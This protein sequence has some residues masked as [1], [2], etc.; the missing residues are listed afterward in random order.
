M[1]LTLIGVGLIAVGIILTYVYMY[2]SDWGEVIG[3]CSIISGVLIGATCLVFI[4]G[5][6]ATVD[7]K[8]YDAEMKRESI[9]RQIEVVNSEYEDVSRAKI[10]QKAYDWN[11]EVY[12][13]KYWTDNKWTSWCHSKEYADS[14]EYIDLEQ[15]EQVKGEK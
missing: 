6:H 5:S 13:E 1:I 3:I 9:I 14:L 15:L 11:R 8:I 4:I 7:T 12:N 2:R 10:I